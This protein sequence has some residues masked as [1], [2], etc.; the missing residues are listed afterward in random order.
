LGDCI[1]IPNT[2]SVEA[3]FSILGWEKDESRSSFT[4]LS[5]EGI[6]HC[7][8]YDAPLFF[9]ELMDVVMMLLGAVASAGHVRARGKCV[10]KLLVP[11]A[12]QHNLIPAA[13]PAPIPVPSPAPIPAPI[14]SAFPSFPYSVHH[15]FCH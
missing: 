13:I 15:Q 14:H 1:G 4:D 6:I 2:A 5:L 11:S 8:Q 10:Y 3:D 9:V 7:K 12:A